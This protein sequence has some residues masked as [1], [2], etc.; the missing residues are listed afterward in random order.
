MKTNPFYPKLVTDVQNTFSQNTY[1]ACVFLDLKGTYDAVD[2]D[3]LHKRLIHYE[4]DE[5][6]ATSITELFKNR[7]IYITDHKNELHGPRFIHNGLPQGSVL[8]PLLLNV[9]VYCGLA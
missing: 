6:V 9:N 8:S 5:N 3:I 2:L 4:V 7:E 1:L